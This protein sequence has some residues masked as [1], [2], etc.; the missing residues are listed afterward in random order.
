MYVVLKSKAAINWSGTAIAN[1]GPVLTYTDPFLQV[2]TATGNLQ[3]VEAH[4]AYVVAT[5]TI[6]GI[7]TTADGIAHNGIVPGVENAVSVDVLVSNLG[8]YIA[9]DTYIT[10]VV[11]SGVVISHTSVTPVAS[12]TGYVVLFMRDLAPGDA[13][14]V[15]L[16][17]DLASPS[18]MRA[19]SV[20]AAPWRLI[21]RTDG[22]FINEFVTAWG[23]TRSVPVFG[24]LAGPLDVGAASLGQRIYLPLV[25]RNYT[26]P[27]TFPVYIGDAIPARPIAYRGE[28]FYVRSVQV[29]S[30]LPPTG[31]F[32]L[33]SR[34]DAVAEVVVDD[35]VTI[36]VN[37]SEVL[38]YDFST[39]GHPTAAIVEVPRTVMVQMAGRTV[40]IEYRDVYGAYVRASAMWLIWM[41]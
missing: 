2:Y 41:P 36:L 38:A 10:I 39:A 13:Q 8:D 29:P 27:V 11:P 23:E 16:L 35:K 31:H 7:T 28:I 12:G 22:S 33:S 5:Y 3:T 14:S 18:A 40:R 21:T 20:A 30:V 1:Y 25:A 34:P 37:G 24:Q 19:Q 32:Y 9:S 17:L 15:S 4:G 26:P 6:K